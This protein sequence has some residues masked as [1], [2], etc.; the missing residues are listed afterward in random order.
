MTISV[1]LAHPAQESFNN[2][3]A[4]TVVATARAAGHT[5]YF[6]DLY[7]EGFDP[8]FTE[9]ELRRD[10]VLPPLVEQHCR[11]LESAD[12]LVVVHPN[13]WSRPP[14]M[15]C[16]WVDRVLRAGR[17]YRFVPDGK[18]G[19]RPEG[20]LRLRKAIVINTSNT[21]PE[22]ERDL[23]GDPLE[24][25]WSKIVFGLCGVREVVRRN[26]GPIIVS[27]EPTRKAWLKEVQ[28]MFGDL[29]EDMQGN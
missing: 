13:Y 19:A 28:A 4:Q 24:A 5:V 29:I 7:R 17:A 8:V 16:G 18:G 12:A 3:L 11:E 9:D 23:F 1:I 6:H 15:M 2:S 21:P 22:K 10:A 27:D 25:H 20:L 26:I 14:A